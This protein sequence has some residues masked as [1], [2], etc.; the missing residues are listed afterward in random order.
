MPA[1][2][3]VPAALPRTRPR[4][5]RPLRRATADGR[6]PR[7]H[8]AGVCG[9]GCDGGAGDMSSGRAPRGD[10]SD[11][12]GPLPPGW[13]TKINRDIDPPRR[14]YYN[15]STGKTSWQRP[16][17]PGAAPGSVAKAP[18]AAAAVAVAVS[19][20]PGA[21]PVPSMTLAAV[22][23]TVGVSEADI[24]EYSAR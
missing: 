3:C 8:P 18:V 12:Q 11:E 2:C 10:T 4:C 9:D 6:R 1:C 24:L 17:A 19:E 5:R 21:S 22:C 23:A 7:A 16:A 20:P 14:M 13:K 15:R